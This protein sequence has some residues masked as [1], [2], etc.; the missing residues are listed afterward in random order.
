MATKTIDK[1]ALLKKY[2][3]ERDKRLRDDGND[4]YI[5]IKAGGGTPGGIRT[6][7]PRFRN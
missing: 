7:D 6:H 5:E 2:H 1:D 3:A 4:Q